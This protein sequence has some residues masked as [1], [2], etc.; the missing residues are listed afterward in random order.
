MNH[1]T[2]IGPYGTKQFNPL[3]AEC[4][5]MAYFTLPFAVWKITGNYQKF[6]NGIST[7]T[8]DK[9]RNAF[10]DVYGKIIVAF[11]QKE[12][13]GDWLIAFNEKYTQRLAEHLQKYLPLSKC[14]K[15]KT[16]LAAYFLD[17]ANPVQD[18]IKIAEKN[19]TI[20][21]AQNPP[22]TP[23]MSADE[24]LAFR[25]ENGISM[26]GVEFDGEMIMN[27]DWQN[28]VCFT[29]GCFLGQEIVTKITHRGKAPQRL[30]R[31]EF[32]NEPSEIKS[33]GAVAG[34]I[35]SKAFSKKSGKWIAYCTIA[36]EA[37]VIDGGRVI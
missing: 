4:I 2:C 18:G 34:E 15:E 13:N 19:S 5:S 1:K 33:E 28:A 22:N 17:S 31:I 14:T 27:T 25:L 35:K 7:N 24:F 37:A 30:E 29:K 23:Q 36:N 9:P 3:A 11:Y 10:L 21:L 20:L 8:L 6:A 26:H 16:G 12:N 32:E